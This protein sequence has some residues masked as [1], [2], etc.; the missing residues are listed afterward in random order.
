MAGNRSLF[1]DVAIWDLNDNEDRIPLGGLM[2]TAGIT[3]TDFHQMLDILLITSGD[4][5]VQNEHGDEVLRDDH[6]L[7]PG[8][9][10]IVADH[11]EFS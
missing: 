6:P 9:Y 8:D 1:R 2:L 11:V 3:N 7:L 10:I 5:L 4:Y